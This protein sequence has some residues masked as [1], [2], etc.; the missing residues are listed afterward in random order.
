MQFVAGEVAGEVVGIG[1]DIIEIERFQRNGKPPGERFMFRCFAESER[2]YLKCRPLETMAGF[3]AAKEAVAKALGTGFVGFWPSAI[4]IVH[5][6]AGKPEVILH[7][8]A[9]GIAEAAGI[10]VL[11]VSISHCRTLAVAMAIAQKS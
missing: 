1:T 4:E 9:K 3:F 2:E 7:G 8:G 5:N 6:R 10:A 11:I